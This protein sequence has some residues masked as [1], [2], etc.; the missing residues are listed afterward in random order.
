KARALD[1][2]ALVRRVLPTNRWG[3]SAAK[4]AT[5]CFER[6]LAT[7][8]CPSEQALYV[9]DNPSKD[10]V[11]V[12]RAGWRTVRVLRGPHAQVQPRPG[13]GAHV[14]ITDLDELTAPLLTHLGLHLESST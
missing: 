6:I 14:D 2:S 9:G 12:R 10:F 1:L 13:Y 11:G 4:P 3:R 7:E 8:G 5:V